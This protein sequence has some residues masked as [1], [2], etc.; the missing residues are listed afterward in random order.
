LDIILFF[1]FGLITLTIYTSL[2]YKANEQV[3]IIRYFRISTLFGIYFFL[4][5]GS[6][7]YLLVNFYFNFQPEIEFEIKINKKSDS[8]VSTPVI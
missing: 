6:L 1:Y 5:F 4:L 8:Q 7:I 3:A 2:N